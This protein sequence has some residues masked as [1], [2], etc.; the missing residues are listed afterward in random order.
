MKTINQ[1]LLL[2]ESSLG[3]EYISRRGGGGGGRVRKTISGSLSGEG[4]K[5]LLFISNGVRVL[6]ARVGKY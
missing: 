1:L 3:M 5:Q 4:P 6:K 2:G